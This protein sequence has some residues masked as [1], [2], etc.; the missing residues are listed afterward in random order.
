[1]RA[2][3][4]RPVW[5]WTVLAIM[6]MVR[7][8]VAADASQRWQ[9]RARASLQ[10]LPGVYV[11]VES[12]DSE[13]ERDGLTMAQVQTDVE[14]RLR[15]AGIQVLTKE[16]WQATP[17][18]PY[19]Y[20]NISLLKD[21]LSPRYFFEIRV[22][23]LQDAYLVRE[24]SSWSTVTWERRV[25]G[26]VSIAS[27]RSIRDHVRDMV[28]AFVN[29]FLAANPS[30]APANAQRRRPALTDEQRAK[31]QQAWDEGKITPKNLPKARRL[32][33]LP[34]DA[35]PPS[36]M[37]TASAAAT[38]HPPEQPLSLQGANPKETTYFM[39]GMAYGMEAFNAGLLLNGLPQLFCRPLQGNILTGKYLWDLAS[40]ALSGPFSPEY[41]DY[42]AIAV[43]TSLQEQFPCT[44]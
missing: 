1:M 22:Q 3:R 36:P 4:L 21:S 41:Y 43:I 32:L 14:L 35:M 18:T 29:D 5:L 40:K 26:R 23:L 10:G 27:L 16:G 34:P 2:S 9:E 28:D 38:K 39:S 25:M 33:G 15:K 17:G 31:I 11:L 44:K 7:A 19:L 6:M 8:S 13:A 37:P 20:V 42:I 12:I 30:R 24:L